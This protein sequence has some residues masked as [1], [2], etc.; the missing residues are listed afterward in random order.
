MK[1][2]YR[3][4]SMHSNKA[5]SNS[6]LHGHPLRVA[7]FAVALTLFTP[8]ILA[9]TFGHPLVQRL[10]SQR[11]MAVV[12]SH[13]I[14]P[15]PVLVH[16]PQVVSATQ[17]ALADITA[18][19][20]SGAQVVTLS[21]SPH[22]TYD[23]PL[24]AGMFTTF[25]IPADEPIQ[26]FAVSNPVAVQLQVNAA[27][28]TAML[29]LVQPITVVGTIVTKKHIF[30]INIMPA[31]DNS[32]WYQGVNWSFDTQTFGSSTF[33]QGVYTN[34]AAGATLASASD[35]ASADPTSTLFTGQP[36]FDYVVKGD[37]PFRPQAVWDNGR[38]TWVQFPKNIQELPA[39]F[40]VGANGL[41]IVN[42]TVHDGGTQ[43]LVNR[44]MPGFVLKLGKS[45]IHVTADR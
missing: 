6:F 19:D 45:E 27:T 44:L 13:E 36:N 17:A 32:P 2:N 42:Y 35:S 5:S 31:N 26:Q 34:P 25:S 20:A 7:S 39:L 30:Y 23:I 12:E 3:P 4:V 37:A 14:P 28:N 33:G 1:R 40:A 43:I 22:A 10:P 11:G 9:G 8:S 15:R 41:E 38:F 16:T 29:K 21:Y 18:S 24:R